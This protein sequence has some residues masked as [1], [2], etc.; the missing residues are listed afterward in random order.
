MSRKQHEPG[1]R[2]STSLV[3]DSPVQFTTQRPSITRRS[4][5]QSTSKELNNQTTTPC[6]EVINDQAISTN[7]IDKSIKVNKTSQTMTSN[8]SNED[9]TSST[10]DLR[11]HSNKN[12]LNIG[13]NGKCLYVNAKLNKTDGQLLI[14]SGSSCC[15]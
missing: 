5:D 2:Q 13:E 4:D 8:V 15:V 9:Q 6:N 1:K 11:E 3:A 10:A 12:A 14:D 7:A